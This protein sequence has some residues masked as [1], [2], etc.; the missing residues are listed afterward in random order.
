MSNVNKIFESGISS[1][2]FCYCL[3]I[4]LVKRLLTHLLLFILLPYDSLH[5]EII[6][7]L[8]SSNTYYH[9]DNNG[10]SESYKLKQNKFA[11]LNNSSQSDKEHHNSGK[12]VLTQDKIS[13]LSLACKIIDKN[14][15]G[16][17]LSLS[18]FLHN[19]ELLES[20]TEER[21]IETL[22]IFILSRLEGKAYEAV[23]SFRDSIEGI[24]TSLRNMVE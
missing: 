20:M 1:F 12:D 15:D 2:Y 19:V 5:D 7:K 16:N 24:K 9:H 23:E 13:F 22:R 8:K 17:P 18:R 10:T 11:S 14:F 3:I 6:F 4:S 21:H